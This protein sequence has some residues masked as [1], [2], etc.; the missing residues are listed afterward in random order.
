MSS[1][2]QAKCTRVLETL[3]DIG[4]L[5]RGGVD[6]VVDIVFHGLHIMV[7]DRL[8][9]GMLCDARGA[10]VLGDG[11]QIVLLRLGERLDAVDDRLIAVAF[12]AIGQQNHPF[13]FHAH[14][15]AV[16][17]R[18]ARD[19]RQAGRWRCDNG[20]QEGVSAIAGEISV[21]FMPFRVLGGAESAA[22]AWLHS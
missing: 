21:S 7:G 6:E 8:V 5:C 3:V 18:L 10:E 11:T 22:W 2:V 19:I 17:R 12:E 20:R 1:E 15:F 13:H 14:A 9:R 4:E 16:E